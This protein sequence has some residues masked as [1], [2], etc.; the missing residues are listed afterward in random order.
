[1]HCPH[2]VKNF[3]GSLFSRNLNGS[4]LPG[5]CATRAW[6]KRSRFEKRV[7]RCATPLSSSL[8]GWNQ[9]GRVVRLL[10]LFQM[11]FHIC[12]FNVE[13]NVLSGLGSFFRPMTNFSFLKWPKKISQICQK[14]LK[15]KTCKVFELF[16]TNEL[17]CLSENNQG[18]GFL[19]LWLSSI[20]V[21]VFKFVCWLKLF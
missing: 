14:M 21:V 20:K 7:T 13:R 9:L 6:W 3:I 1:M 5:N 4:L 8:T 11:L 16:W 19:G 18:L 15:S 2:I 10:N 17:F 12:V